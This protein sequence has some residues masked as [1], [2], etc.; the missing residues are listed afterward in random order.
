[1]NRIRMAVLAAGIAALGLTGIAGVS[2]AGGKWD[3]HRGHGGFGPGFLE[4]VDANGD[5]RATQAEID[6][7][8][9]DRLAEFDENGDGSL[10]L[11]EFQALWLSV[12]RERMVDSFQALDDDGDA[13]VTLEEYVE[14]FSHVVS[15]LDRNDDGELTSD[16]MRRR[17]GHHGRHER[18]HRG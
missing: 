16:D 18:E 8:R 13:V 3:G 9:Q 5:G 10:T 4:R 11:E 15:R 2:Q 1:M 6:Q 17:H 14:P 12:M 7:I